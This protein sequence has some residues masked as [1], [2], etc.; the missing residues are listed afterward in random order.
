MA[1]VPTVKS[2]AV[3]RNMMCRALFGAVLMVMF[4]ANQAAYAGGYCY[5]DK[6][7]NVIY[8]GSSFYFKSEKSCPTEWCRLQSGMDV[9]VVD[10]YY[11]AILVAYSQQMPIH[12]YWSERSADSC[13][14]V[15]DSETERLSGFVLS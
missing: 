11:S 13:A 15:T 6:I 7:I 2:G 3:R 8:H 12:L 10:R 14:A 9:T 1:I 4:F 5:N